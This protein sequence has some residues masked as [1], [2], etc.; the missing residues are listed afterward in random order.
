MV[1]GKPY[2]FV[3]KSRGCFGTELRGLRCGKTPQ[4]GIKKRTNPKIDTKSEGNFAQIVF[5]LRFLQTYKT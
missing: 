2:F 1:A 5:I 3:E 4:N